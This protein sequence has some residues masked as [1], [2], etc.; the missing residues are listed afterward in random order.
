MRVRTEVRLV[1]QPADLLVLAA[2]GFD[3]VRHADLRARFGGKEGGFEDYVLDITTAQL[4]FL[5]QEFQV[6]IARD[7]RFFR[8]GAPP[9]LQSVQLLRHGEFNSPVHT[10]DEGIVHILT[11]VRGE[12]DDPV[13]LFHALQ[14]V[15]YLQVG[16]AVVAVFYFAAL[17][18]EGVGLVEEEDGVG[19]LTFMEDL[20]QVLFGLAYILADHRRQ[21]YFVQ[22]KPQV[23]GEDLGGHRLA[24]AWLAREQHV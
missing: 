19:G 3:E 11:Q 13:V 22:F 1:E 21:V 8:E 12:D 5:S 6:Q 20:L 15:R 24:R 14:E 9:Y 23:G 10:P 7:R 2:G 17:A 18:E 16:V 4:E